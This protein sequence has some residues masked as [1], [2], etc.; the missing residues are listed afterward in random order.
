MNKDLE[1]FRH[2]VRT[3]NFMQNTSGV[4]PGLVQG[5]VVILP[6]ET[7]ENFIQF[8]NL[9]ST[10]CPIIAVSKVGDFSLPVLGSN[11][12]I[13]Y[14]IPEYHLFKHGSF[15]GSVTNIVDYWQE[16]SVAIVLGCSFSFER[17][18]QEAN[19]SVR[20]AEL[21]V[22]VSMYDTSIP[23]N[24]TEHF[25]GNMVVSMRPFKKDQIEKVIEITE[26]YSNSHG[27][28]V[29][30]GEPSE[31]GIDNIAQP[32]YGST[33]PLDDD[34]VLAFWGCGVTTQRVLKQKNI[35][36]LITHAPGKM[37]VADHSYDK[38]FC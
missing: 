26:K 25:A 10:P 14:D 31:I 37:L 12:D 30:I 6:Q 20:N 34:D 11:L 23:L 16:D 18:L 13:R 2:D 24:S 38:L 35:P 17:A 15:F 21:G 7:A 27:S 3:G 33:V 19:I 4:L 36:F 29:H 5:N 9:N 22:N 1:Q 28:P 32:E 8:C